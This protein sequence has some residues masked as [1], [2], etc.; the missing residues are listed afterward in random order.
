MRL[1]HV[2]AWH[3]STLSL[4]RGYAGQ[5]PAKALWSDHYGP[6]PPSNPAHPPASR[7]QQ[8]SSTTQILLS[9]STQATLSRFSQ[10]PS[11]LPTQVRS[12]SV[13]EMAGRITSLELELHNME[14][15]L[16]ATTRE[17]E[18][19]EKRLQEMEEALHTMTKAKDASGAKLNHFLADLS[20]LV[21]RMSNVGN[22]E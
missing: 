4:Q 12:T 19:G 10:M 9:P 16:C 11:S 15:A 1:A 21:Q 17:K 6:Q 7:T 22:I 5:E 13:T 20:F 8:P 18:A 3:A 14:N 2:S